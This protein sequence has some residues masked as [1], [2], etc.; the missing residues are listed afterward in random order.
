MNTLD[1]L[2][3]LDLSKY[4]RHV[5]Q[6]GTFLFTFDTEEAARCRQFFGK[7]SWQKDDTIPKWSHQRERDAD[8]VRFFGGFRVHEE[9]IS[10]VCM[11]VRPLNDERGC[12]LPSAYES[13]SYEWMQRWYRGQAEMPQST[14][15]LDQQLHAIEEERRTVREKWEKRRADEERQRKA[16]GIYYR[17][18][19]RRFNL[20]CDEEERDEPTNCLVK[21]R[22]QQKCRDLIKAFGLNPTDKD[23]SDGTIFTQKIGENSIQL[24]F[25]NPLRGGLN[26]Y[27]V[28]SIPGH[29]DSRSHYDLEHWISDNKHKRYLVTPEGIAEQERWKKKLEDNEA[30]R[31]AK[32]KKLD[33][34]SSQERRQLQDQYKTSAIPPKVVDDLVVL[35]VKETNYQ[36]QNTPDRR[37]T[38]AP[39]I[40][41][42]KELIDALERFKALKPKAE[43]EPGYGRLWAVWE[44]PK[45]AH[46][47]CNGFQ[48]R[49][50]KGHDGETL[51]EIR[52]GSGGWWTGPNWSPTTLCLQHYM[53]EEAITNQKQKYQEEKT[54]FL[55]H[56]ELRELGI[57]E[58]L[59]F[60]GAPE[61]VMRAGGRIAGI[62]C[63][64]G[65][66]LTDPT[67]M[68]LGI[69][70]ECIQHAAGE[71]GMSVLEMAKLFKEEEF[72]QT[73][74]I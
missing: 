14:E 73:T 58:I 21:V 3:Q 24:A 64:C 30:E 34:Q 45:L 36:R 10:G 13:A 63:R 42:S 74:L 43:F 29:D 23:F 54:L 56:C 35:A 52:P 62:C 7:A 66:V 39:P 11:I 16:L 68:A 57:L 72:K 44:S 17:E 51:V 69:G 32:Q 28:M 65:R 53:N 25:L 50:G 49:A 40:P 22:A 8:G 70:P 31:A 26:A 9:N 60:A 47:K 48:L 67:S 71:Y 41:F 18:F 12:S 59:K 15:E 5:T 55:I 37:P 46:G 20:R 6:E 2:E 61:E 19:C 38:F 27:V 33:D 1:E 4:R